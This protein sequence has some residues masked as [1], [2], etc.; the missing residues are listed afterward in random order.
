M[1][2]PS[3]PG[4]LAERLAE[5]WFEEGCDWSTHYEPAAHRNPPSWTVSLEWTT[6]RS[7]HHGADFVA[8]TWQFYGDTF[9]DALSGAVEWLEHL[10]PWKRCDACDGLGDQHQ[11]KCERCGGDGFDRVPSSDEPEGAA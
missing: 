9:E 6:D 5:L 4:L 2:S 11:A 7:Y 1:D 8:L 10:A 3:V